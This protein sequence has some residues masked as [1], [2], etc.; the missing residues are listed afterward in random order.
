MFKNKE[1]KWRKLSPIIL[2]YF[3][4]PIYMQGKTSS[5]WSK[6][7]SAIPAADLLGDFWTTYLPKKRIGFYQILASFNQ[8]TES[9]GTPP[10]N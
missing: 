7:P 8:A 5:V 4:G 3:Q 10:S 6:K 2:Q 1:K 9:P